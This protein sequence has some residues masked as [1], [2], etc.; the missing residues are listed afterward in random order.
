MSSTTKGG[1]WRPGTR[2]LDLVRVGLTD[3]VRVR[4]RV[5]VAARVRVRVS[6]FDRDRVLPTE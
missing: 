3:G 4:V 1:R 6:G 5:S 2:G